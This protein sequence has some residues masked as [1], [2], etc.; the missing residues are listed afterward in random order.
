MWQEVF[1]S[2]IGLLEKQQILV[3]KISKTSTCPSDSKRKKIPCHFGGKGF[4]TLLVCDHLLR[5]NLGIDF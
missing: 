4:A 5:S 1:F 3:H 2:T